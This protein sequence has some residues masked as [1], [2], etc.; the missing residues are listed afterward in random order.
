MPGT[1]VSSKLLWS[2]VRDATISHNPDYTVSFNAISRMP[3]SYPPTATGP[4]RVYILQ[5]A[6]R[7]RK[8]GVELTDGALVALLSPYEFDGVG[9]G[10]DYP[11][12]ADILKEVPVKEAALRH[13]AR[14]AARGDIVNRKAFLYSQ[15]FAPTTISVPQG[16]YAGEPQCLTLHGS[17][18]GL[19]INDDGTNNGFFF[20][21]V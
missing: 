20:D 5:Y 21:T 16:N 17:G 19:N 13:A 8:W 3:P 18:G 9:V 4:A 2:V 14:E 11:I 10:F 1:E 6:N 15:V 7:L 12:Y